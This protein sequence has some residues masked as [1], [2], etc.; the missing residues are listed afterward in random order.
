MDKV[1][2]INTHDVFIKRCMMN[3]N[4][5]YKKKATFSGWLE[6]E[7]EDILR[8]RSIQSLLQLVLLVQE[9]INLMPG[10]RCYH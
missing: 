3:M 6:Q 10:L 9:H 2:E 1:V 5:N 4:P 8:L 7:T